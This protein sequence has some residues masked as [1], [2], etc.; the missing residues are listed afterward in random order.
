MNRI[1][2]QAI[3]KLV[4]GIVGASPESEVPTGPALK[5]WRIA[6]SIQAILVN[7]DIDEN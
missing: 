7:N 6:R 4:N 3:R 5:Y 1:I 2:L